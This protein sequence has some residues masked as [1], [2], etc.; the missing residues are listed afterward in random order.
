M[1]SLAFITAAVLGCVSSVLGATDKNNLT[2][3]ASSEQILSGA[4]KPPQVFKNSNLVRIINLEKGYPKE[5]V[6][7]IIENVASSPQDEYFLPFTAT[8]MENIGVLEVK[9][10]KNVDSPLFEVEAV[11]IDPERY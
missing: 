8:Q 9:D 4:F 1:K 10:R 7:V 5:T 6:N 11:E 3:P 2:K